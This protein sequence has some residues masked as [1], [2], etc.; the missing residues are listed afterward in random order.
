MPV[1]KAKEWLKVVAPK[2]FEEKVIGK[3]LV[4]EEKHAIGR[5]VIVNTLELTNNSSKYYLNFFFRIVKVEKDTAYTEFDGFECTRDYISRMVLHRVKRIDVVQDILTKD[6]VKLRVK[7]LV[8]A[9]KGIGEKSRK[10]MKK[11][12]AEMVSEFVQNSSIEDFL[13]KTMTDEAKNR[14][15]QELRRVYPLRYFEIRKVEVLR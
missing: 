10:M 7:S 9:Q 11:R 1:K 8:V 5:R 2:F 6:G 14:I 3:F 4:S 12:A 13:R 15:S